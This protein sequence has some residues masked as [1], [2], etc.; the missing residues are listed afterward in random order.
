MKTNIVHVKNFNKSSIFSCGNAILLRVT[1]I[2]ACICLLIQILPITSFS[3]TISGSYS[4]MKTYNS[5]GNPTAGSVISGSG[6][7]S[8]QGDLVSI[9]ERLIGICEKYSDKSI[10]NG[11]RN[12]INWMKQLYAGAVQGFVSKLGLGDTLLIAL[13]N[14]SNINTTLLT[15]SYS[16]GN[17]NREIARKILEGAEGY[18][19]VDTIAKA[20]GLKA[21][22]VRSIL[23][24]I[25]A[26]TITEK[27]IA[28]GKNRTRASSH[29]VYINNQA[30]KQDK[31]YK[32][33][34]AEVERMSGDPDSL[35]ILY[36]DLGAG[37][38]NNLLSGYELDKYK[39]ALYKEYL[40][41]TLDSTLDSKKP[42][43]LTTATSAD[44]YKVTKG[45]TSALSDLFAYEIGAAEEELSEEL[46]NFLK[47]HLD[48]GI[49]NEGEA[50]EYLILSGNFGEEEQGIEEAAKQLTK[51]YKHLSG[52]ETALDTVGDA[53]SIVEKVK[54]AGDFCEYWVTDYAQQEILLD[55]LV[56]TLSDS[57]ADMELLVAAKE[58]QEEYEDKQSGT[59]DKAYAT[60][61]DEGIGAVKSSFPPLAITE[62]CI[63]LAGT[64]TGADDQVEALETGL[65]MQGICKQ[66]LEDYEDAVIAV[67]K[68]DTSE[69]AVSR[70]LTTFEIAR[71]SLISYYGA[72]VTLAETQEEENT[73][74]TELTK[75]KNLNFT[76]TI[77]PSRISG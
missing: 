62:T 63:S 40:A 67:N 5:S 37:Y 39:V 60:L 70:V 14:H 1:S 76:D 43:S 7:K 52:L 58:L 49:L 29:G 24:R 59:F 72:M 56:D 64:L 10:T 77:A 36:E 51:G 4:Y 42:Y 27:T 11:V 73:Y 38:V 19:N 22:D 30:L 16:M 20:T 45:T 9:I 57:G 3:V 48:D 23:E 33:L 75:L 35:A 71:Q 13:L 66:A 26:G 69:E 54:L 44:A 15:S 21:K 50:R 74:A 65:A 34:L 68:G 41:K 31:V 55:D 6:G 12:Q 2:V 28:V 25:A 53:V 61:I 47:K 18:A 17:I 32:Y 8:Y 46:K